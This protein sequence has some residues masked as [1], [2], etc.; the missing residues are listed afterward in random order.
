MTSPTWLVR[1]PPL[2]V[3]S[4][5]RG[6]VPP[7]SAKMAATKEDSTTFCLNINN[8]LFKEQS[9][10]IFTSRYFFHHGLWLPQVRFPTYT[11]SKLTVKN[12]RHSWMQR[13]WPGLVMVTM[14]GYQ[15]RRER[16][17]KFNPYKICPSGKPI[18]NGLLVRFQT[19]RKDNADVE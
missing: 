1:S 18:K 4:A 11:N 12:V 9:Y 14:M 19:L 17:S 2:K 16:S 5:M 8:S 10:N 7:P 15:F 6:L 3:L 13:A